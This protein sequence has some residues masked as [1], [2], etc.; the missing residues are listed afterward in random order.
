MR[1]LFLGTAD[2]H[3][4]ALREHSGI[5]IQTGEA[6]L[7]LDCGAAAARFFLRKKLSADTPEILF[8][9]HMHSDHIGQV[10]SLI[11]S[12]WLHAP[13]PPAYHRPGRRTHR[14]EGLAGKMPPFP[15]AGRFPDRVAG[16][17]AGKAV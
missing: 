5:L 3:T 10:A 9:S 1:A 7:L 6:S 2:G 13:R 4:S 14:D 8:I 11:Q 12:L 17:Q 15:R 16:D